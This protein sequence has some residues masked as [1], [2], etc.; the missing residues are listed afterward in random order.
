MCGIVAYLGPHNATDI[1]LD[2][3]RRLEYRGYDSCGIAVLAKGVIHEKR[4]VGPIQ[5]LEPKANEL[6]KTTLGIGHTRW[7]THG[8]PNEQNA[9]P[10][11]D[12]G[13][14]FALVHNG[15][16]ENYHELKQ[17]L[18]RAGHHFRSETDTEVLSHLLEEEYKT[19]SSLSLSTAVANVLT[20]VHGT[21]GLAVLDAHQP[22]ELVI[23]RLGSPMAIGIGNNEYI[24]ASDPSAILRYTRQVIFLDDYELA[25][26]KQT[27]LQIRSLKTTSSIEKSPQLLDWSLEDVQKNGQPHFMLKEILEEG[28]TI[29]NTMRGRLHKSQ[30]T[31]ILGG[32]KDVMPRLEQVQ[33]LILVGC[34]TA[35]Y[36]GC[37]GKYLLESWTGIPTDVEIASEFRYRDPVIS[38]DTAVVAISQSGETADTL[39]ALREGMMKGAL[40]LGI[41]NVVGSTIA[42]ETEAGVYTHAGPEISVASTKAFISQCT[43]LALLGLL[44]GRTK[45]LSHTEGSEIVEALEKLPAQVEDLLRQKDALQAI[46]KGYASTQSLLCVGRK[47][48]APIAYEGALKVKEVSY[49]HA[50]GYPAGEI[51]HGP[52][53]LVD[54]DLPCI[55]LCPKDSV[56]SKTVS[57]IQEIRARAGKVLAITTPDG[58]EELKR[59]ANDIIIVPKT[60]EALQPILS[61][62]PLQLLAYTLAVERGHNPDRPRNLAKSVTVE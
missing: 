9:H 39:A 8:Q 41:V 16:I 4:A 1:L 24:I 22:E 61:V 5:T 2:G 50:E 23:A 38:K 46:A 47:F 15:I 55:V 48:H 42:R 35:Y 25:T 34:G 45:R 19:K 13:N 44:L 11:V 32:L 37:V 56:F 40:G 59:Y 58:A 17:A 14:R 36:A 52:L 57:N 12:C 3:L 30:G 62:I 51:K 31:A 10:H 27:G 33:R 53:A 54:K 43:T 28:E 6:P 7:A 29:R 49:I 21:Y 18:V 20:Q 60:L 26:I